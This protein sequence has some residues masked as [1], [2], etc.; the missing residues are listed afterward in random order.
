MAYKI[1]TRRDNIIGLIYVIFI[2]RKTMGTNSVILI[3]EKNT[4][5]SVFYERKKKCLCHLNKD[6]KQHL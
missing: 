5:F 4:C 6:R 3:A 1:Q 2:H